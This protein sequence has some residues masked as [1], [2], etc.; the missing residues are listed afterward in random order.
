[1][2]LSVAAFE[3]GADAC[4]IVLHKQ[5]VRS[6]SVLSPRKRR[7]VSPVEASTSGTTAER[8]DTFAE[9]KE[10]A[11]A[12]LPMCHCVTSC[13]ISP[14][15][16]EPS[17]SS[18]QDAAFGEPEENRDVSPSYMSPARVESCSRVILPAVSPT[19]PAYRPTGN[20]EAIP[21]VDISSDEDDEEIGLVAERFSPPASP[22]ISD[23][24][25]L[26]EISSGDSI[27]IISPCPSPP[28]NF[29]LT[30]NMPDE[31]INLSQAIDLSFWGPS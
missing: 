14:V 2:L 10:A 27:Q 17:P 15:W 28:L 4:V 21:F 6:Q 24:I 1:M 11:D 7:R 31:D 13:C 30:Q 19:S 29:G 23:E 20:S 12:S 26:I 25:P 9:P 3:D 22:S 8:A 16:D 5:S 18:P